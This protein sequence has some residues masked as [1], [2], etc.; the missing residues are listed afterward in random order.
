MLDLATLQDSMTQALLKG[1]LSDIEDEFDTGMTGPP[2]SIL[3]DFI[4]G[5]LQLV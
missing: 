1:D 3:I 5:G 4:A 2:L